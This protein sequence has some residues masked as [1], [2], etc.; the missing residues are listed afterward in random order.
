M[1][2]NLFLSLKTKTTIFG[3]RLLITYVINDLFEILRNTNEFRH[4]FK[5]V[6]WNRK[7][8]ASEIS[9]HKFTVLFFQMLNGVLFASETVSRLI[10][11]LNVFS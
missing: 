9:Y 1:M 3:L 4:V 5:C 11:Y 2:T 10:K 8:F 6:E 7:T